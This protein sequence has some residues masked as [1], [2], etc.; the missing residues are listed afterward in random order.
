MVNA[1]FCVLVCNLAGKRVGKQKTDLSPH[2]LVTSLSAMK[3]EKFL[4]I[5]KAV[6]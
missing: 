2:P 5:P 4:Q 3:P 1:D 6:T